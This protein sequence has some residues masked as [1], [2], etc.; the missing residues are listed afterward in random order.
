M[1]TV[2][3]DTSQPSALCGDFLARNHPPMFRQSAQMF[4]GLVRHRTHVMS[5]SQI[6]FDAEMCPH[7]RSCPK[8]TITNFNRCNH[9]N[10]RTK[11]ICQTGFSRIKTASTNWFP[12]IHTNGHHARQQGSDCNTTVRTKVQGQLVTKTEVVV[13]RPWHVGTMFQSSEV[14]L[15]GSVESTNQCDLCARQKLAIEPDILFV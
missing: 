15:G 4:V 6:G 11:Y 7:F 8:H 10:V 13:N 1:S 14:L 9:C 3:L 5:V 2:F 12:R